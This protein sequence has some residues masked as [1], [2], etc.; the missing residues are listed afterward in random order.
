MIVRLLVDF[1]LLPESYFP[2][3]PES[4]FYYHWGFHAV[5]AF[6]AWISG[7]T[8]WPEVP[9][10]ILGLG[11]LLN[12]L[13]LLSPCT[14]RE[15]RCFAAA[16]P[17]FSRRRWPRWCRSFP[18][19]TFPGD[20]T[21]SSADLLLLPPLA[22][23]FWKLGRHPNA[24]L[25]VQV[26]LLAAGLLLI[27]VRVVVVFAVLA[28]ILS[29]FMILQRRWK[30]SALVRDRRRC[31]AAHRGAVDGA[32]RSRATGAEDRRA[33]LRR[34]GAMGDLERRSGRHR[35]GSSQTRCCSRWPAVGCSASLR[36]D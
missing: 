21:R 18:R 24:R 11:Q 5:A 33:L 4:S 31:R 22:S 23:S 3:I 8:S 25:A 10:M 36:F 14:A 20:A 1:G 26:A 34:A 30:G 29:V 15:R 17:P 35:L 9:R 6:V 28:A 2:F 16:A 7:L 32:A 27:H 12:V 19:T 13:I